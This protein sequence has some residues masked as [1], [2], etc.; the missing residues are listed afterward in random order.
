MLGVV[1]GLV[2]SA[3]W[4]VADFL[5]GQQSRKMPAL[6]VL[7]VTQPIG[8]LLALIVALSLGGDGIARS[9]ALLGVLAGVVI[10]VALVA[11]YRGMAI[12]PVSIVAT[13]ASLGVA[14]P[15]LG[16]LIQGESPGPLQLAGA[17]AAIIGVA[18][19]S[20]RPDSEHAIDRKVLGLAAFAALGIGTFFLLVDSAAGE[21]PGWAIFAVRVGGVS[22]LVAAALVIRPRIAIERA[23]VPPLVAI[24]VLEIAANLLF[25]VATNHGLLSLVSVAGSLYSAVTVLLAWL[26]LGERLFG[27]QRI[28][29]VLAL[30][31]VAAIAAGA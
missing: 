31:G 20:R 28:G 18:M 25:A 24:G 27:A 10:V 4:G 17:V 7:L 6:S 1:L 3:A 8:L 5:G 13:I 19:V 16:G 15:F 22:T 30:G 14:V 11:F 23:S 2:S 26:V 29:V 9:D 21:E 12:G